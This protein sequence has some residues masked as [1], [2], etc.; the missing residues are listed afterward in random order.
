MAC[1]AFVELGYIMKKKYDSY[2][3]E[4]QM[5]TACAK[6]RIENNEYN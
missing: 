6:V 3:F 1:S 5:I 4:K 2:K